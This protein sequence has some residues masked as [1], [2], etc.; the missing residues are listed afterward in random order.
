MNQ[1]HNDRSVEDTSVVDD[2]MHDRLVNAGASLRSWTPTGDATDATS[3]LRAIDGGTT[4]PDPVSAGRRRPV[5]LP[6]AASLA[7]LAGAVGVGAL[8]T[9]GQ[10]TPVPVSVATAPDSTEAL[11]DGPPAEG[12]ENARYSGTSVQASERA[13]FASDVALFCWLREQP[14][15]VVD[16]DGVI[17]AVSSASG[18]TAWYL[19]R[20][21]IVLGIDSHA[22]DG[23]IDHARATEIAADVTSA[24][25]AVID[26][27]AATACLVTPVAETRVGVLRTFETGAYHHTMRLASAAPF[28]QPNPVVADK[29]LSNAHVIGEFKG[30]GFDVENAPFTEDGSSIDLEGATLS[31]HLTGG[32]ALASGMHTTVFPSSL[33]PSEFNIIEP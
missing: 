11:A 22:D 30:E 18:V 19:N 23:A 26:S 31:F 1:D 9:S 25:A 21:Q 27:D 12:W 10:D 20:G 2:P 33:D 24:I 15:E 14:T 28:V 29:S 17:A 13:V 32:D 7:M 16:E 3:P 4:R 5:L 8:V 6:V